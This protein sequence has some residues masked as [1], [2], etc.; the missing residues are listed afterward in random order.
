MQEY[1][2]TVV[3]SPIQSTGE[4]TRVPEEPGFVSEKTGFFQFISWGAIAGGTIVAMGIHILLSALG[5]GVG[6]STFEP[7]TDSN[8]VGQLSVMAAILWTAGALIALWSGGYVAG[9]FSHSLRSGAIHGVIVWSLALV[10]TVLMLSVGTGM[11]LGGAF[12]V[13]G[14]GIGT[15]GAVVA[16][17]I[18]ELAKEGIKR[19]DDQLTSFVDEAIQAGPIESTPQASTRAKREIGFAVTKLFA[20]GNDVTSQENR[21]AVTTALVEYTGMSE[22]DASKHVTD[23]TA[24]YNKLKAELDNLATIAAQKTREAADVAAQRM[25]QASLWS[26][27]ALLMGL[28]IASI[29]GRAGAHSSLKNLGSV[30]IAER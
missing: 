30:R 22:A 18:G 9:R 24:S 28:I 25:S 29:G 16:D 11:V 21:A 17:G 1:N 23:W 3:D 8:P 6:L 2:S 12:K 14:A 27:L 26:F 13:I 4:T 19:S 15:G 10:I 5:V 7:L 20:P